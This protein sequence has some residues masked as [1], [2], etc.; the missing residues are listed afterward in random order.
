M[1]DQRYSCTSNVV[2]LL[3]HMPNLESIQAGRP[4]PIMVHVMPTHRCQLDCVHCC[5]KNRADKTLD[6]DRNVLMDGVGQFRRMGVRAVE[7]TG[8]GEPTLYPYLGQ[9]LDYMVDGLGVAVGI[10]TNGLALPKIE[11]LIKYFKWIRVSL[12]TLDYRKAEALQPGVDLALAS[13][14]RV[15]FCYIWNDRSDE[16]IREVVK[17]S[18]RNKIVCRVAPDCIQPIKMISQQMEHIRRRLGFFKSEFLFLSDFNVTLSRTGHHCYIHQIKPAMYAD[19]YVYPC[20]SAELAVESGK[21]INPA[22]RLCHASE[23]IEFYTSNKFPGCLEHTCSYCKYSQQNDL[24][25]ALLTETVDNEF[26]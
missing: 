20:P 12:N 21:K 24:L 25:E 6:M 19:G 3:K 8:G 17:F 1:V 10:C 4:A 23:V 13:G 11:H 14:A 5:F 26:A 22:M 9:C 15:T 16:H 18:D 7:L 2:K